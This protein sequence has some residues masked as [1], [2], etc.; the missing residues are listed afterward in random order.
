MRAAKGLPWKRVANHIAGSSQSGLNVKPIFQTSEYVRQ[1]SDIPSVQL[2]IMFRNYVIRRL[3]QHGRISTRC[4]LRRQDP[5]LFFRSTA[6]GTVV[7]PKTSR[8]GRE[9]GSNHISRVTLPAAN[10]HPSSALAT[11][12]LP[13]GFSRILALTTALAAQSEAIRNLVLTQNS[14]ETIRKS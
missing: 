9:T 1:P 7:L 5:G 13:L 8:S 14:P 12:G 10:P 2:A 4:G 3:N 11:C 6:V